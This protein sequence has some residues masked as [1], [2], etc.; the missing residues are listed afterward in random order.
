MQVPLQLILAFLSITLLQV[1]A[2]KG[3]PQLELKLSVEQLK[4][5]VPQHFTFT[6]TNISDNEIRLPDP[7]LGCEKS[8]RR[9]SFWLDES[10]ISL[11]GERFKVGGV[12]D[13]GYYPSSSTT[14]IDSVKK[15]RLLKPGESLIVMGD[16]HEFHYEM[17]RPGI[18]LF[19]GVYFPPYLSDEERA[20]LRQEGIVIPTQTTKSG[21][22]QYTKE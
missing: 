3:E 20:S 19:S 5:G 1:G 6:L 17:S 4:A 7:D 14:L 16:E 2:A 10:W 18:Y 11:S 8:T 9:G 13:A 22:L 15:W 12:C 21:Q